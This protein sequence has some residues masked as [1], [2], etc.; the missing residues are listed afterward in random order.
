M[1]SEALPDELT[2]RTD[3][4]TIV[5]AYRALNYRGGVE[6]DIETQSDV[7]EEFNRVPISQ[8]LAQ[9]QRC[10]PRALGRQQSAIPSLSVVQNAE[11]ASVQF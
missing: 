1:L 8:L 4:Q 9:C 6:G 10:H 7:T 11:S 5:R 2:L 3:L